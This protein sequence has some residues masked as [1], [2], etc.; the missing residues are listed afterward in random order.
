MATEAKVD[1]GLALL[2][3]CGEWVSGYSYTDEESVD[4]T[5]YPE[6][7]IVQYDNSVYYSL[8]DDNISTPG[9]DDTKWRCWVNGQASKDLQTFL[10]SQ[11]NTFA[12]F[13]RQTDATSGD[14]ET[15]YG[16]K[17]LI[18]EI[19]SH[20]KMFTEKN[21]MKQHVME[22]TRIDKATNGDDVAIDGTDGD[23]Y[24]GWVDAVPQLLKGKATVD[25]KETDIIGI[26]LTSA[27]W[28]GIL[29]KKLPK[30]GI[31][32]MGEV[33]AKINDDT[34]SQQHCVYN[35]AAVGT[36]TAPSGIFK[37]S[38]K[39]SG[40]G[41]PTQ[42]TSC[43]QSIQRAQAK[44]S[45]SNTNRP[46]M[47][48]YYEFYEAWITLL[49]AE[50][51]S[52]SHTALT[53]FGTGLTPLDNVSATTFC[54]DD[55]SANSGWKIIVSDT[56][57]RYTNVWANEFLTKDGSKVNMVD[58]IAGSSHYGI[59]EMLEPQRV[60]SA[61]SKAGLISQ[62]GDKSHIFYYDDNGDMQ[63]STDGSIDV[64][65]GTGMTACKH[66]FIVRDVPNCEGMADGV[67]TAVVNS[68]TLMEF[69]DGITITS[70]ST[71]L[72]GC[73][74][75]LKRSMAVYRG[76]ILPYCYGCFEQIDGAFYVI[77]VDAD[78]NISME[79]RCAASVEDLPARTSFGYEAAVDGEADIEKGLSKVKKYDT[80]LSTDSWVKACDLSFSLFCVVSSGGGAR[81]YAN[82]YLWVYT[83]NNAGKGKRQVHGSVVGCYLHGWYPRP[84]VRAVNGNNHAGV[85][86][87]GYVGASA[88][89]LVES[90]D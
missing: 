27:Y 9:S 20:F 2:K 38:Y 13:A 60:L 54:D 22:G 1:L 59:V 80:N 34:V 77:K 87:D 17:E 63:C 18:H 3:D 73:K 85:G 64:T 89:L 4:H 76:K 81:S 55:I 36:Y 69:A 19:G 62:I 53:A 70:D 33:N 12:G 43:V 86:V 32:A 56:D 35:T 58:G 88:V 6:G 79:F 47:G 25:E 11:T 28:N 90:E 52:V 61:I 45:D 26:G 39:A 83:S 48:E 72:D 49:F 51:G 7:A 37:A 78:G 68:Y 75:I 24:V 74:A 8:V 10:E 65:T 15:S 66:Y 71:A 16:S 42:Y 57:A 23:I 67:M 5:G 46:H 30:H 44:N 84:S 29:S 14:A 50:L 21:G 41:Y 82:M 40:A 31:C